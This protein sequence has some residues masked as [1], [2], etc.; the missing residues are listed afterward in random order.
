MT[1]IE[2]KQE[3]LDAE[4]RWPEDLAQMAKRIEARRAYFVSKRIIDF[5][6]AV[7]LLIMLS[8]LMLLIGFIIRA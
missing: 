5:A 3:S 2:F 8:P 1:T 4:W 7:F 6:A